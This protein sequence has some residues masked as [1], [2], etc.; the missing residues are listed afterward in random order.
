MKLNT[1][2]IILFVLSQ[3]VYSTPFNENGLKD[4]DNFNDD[5]GNVNVLKDEIYDSLP[6]D[7]DDVIDVIDAKIDNEND[8]S[9]DEEDPTVSIIDTDECSSM[10]CIETSKRILSSLDTSVNPCNDFYEFSCGGWMQIN[11]DKEEGYTQ[12]SEIENKVI[13]DLDD[14]LTSNYQENEKLSSKEK[15][16]DKFLFNKIKTIYT[17]CTN[18]FNND[19]NKNENLIKFINKFN[20]TKSLN[21][22][23]SFTTLLAECN[24]NGINLFFA[25]ELAKIKNNKFPYKYIPRIETIAQDSPYMYKIPLALSKIESAKDGGDENL[26]EEYEI[27][28]NYKA[29]IKKVLQ[30]I[31]GSNKNESEIDSKVESIIEVEKRISAIHRINEN[32]EYEYST[33]VIDGYYEY[34]YSTD[35]VDGYYEYNTDIELTEDYYEY[36]TE[37]EQ[38]NYDEEE[39]YFTEFEYENYENIKS[40]NEKYPLID[41]KLYFEKVF[42]YYNIEISINEELMMEGDNEFEYLYEI[43]NKIEN[44]D[45]INYLEWRIICTVFDVSSF[46]SS[47]VSEELYKIKKEFYKYLDVEDNVEISVFYGDDAK[48]KCLNTLSLVMPLALS[49]FYVEKKFPEDIKSLSMDMVENIRNAMISKIKKLEWLDKSTREY[50]INKVLNIKYMLAYSDSIMNIDN[51]Y[52]QYKFLEQHEEDNYLSIVLNLINL[53]TKPIFNLIYNENPGKTTLYDTPVISDEVIPT[54]QV[55]AFYY[56]FDNSMKFPVSILQMPFFSKNQPNYINY[57]ALGYI[58]GHE[59]THAFDSDGRSYDS[60]GYYYNWWTDNDDKEFSEYSQCFIDQYNNYYLEINGKKYYVDGEDTLAENL[61]DNGAIERS[62]KA[63]KLSIETNPETAD[64][65][66][67]KLPGLS[68]YTMDQLFYI[69]FAQTLCEVGV[70]EESFYDF[71]SPSKL[72]VNGVVINDKRFAEV[73]NCPINSPM[74][75]EHKCSLW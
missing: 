14:I 72:R 73:F 25:I 62:Y 60:E 36:S 41:W 40:F 10:E 15:E 31:Y 6:K 7:I 20:V 22:R 32:Y 51:V 39:E 68:E 13:N 24:N 27:Y 70:K 28:N 5:F 30:S 44:K 33:D 57:G 64:Q 59:L 17:S 16:Q 1:I 69:S 45:M 74:N 9:S 2:S 49:K 43:I 63:W 26:E 71:H 35:V 23:E 56:K 55:N 8:S 58:M 34:E 67:K 61:A 42:E 21:N 12:F 11:S 37:N 52:N 65:L 19:D 3:R 38:M 29:F 66:N 47:L 50:A 46:L 75:P 18:N 54:Y 4:V 48:R 53:D